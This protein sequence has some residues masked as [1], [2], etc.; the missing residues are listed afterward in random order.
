MKKKTIPFNV[1]DD[2]WDDGH[3]PPGDVQQTFGYIEEYE[4]IN[5]KDKEPI[6]QFIYDYI[7]KHIDMTEVKMEILGTQIEFINLTHV[8]REYMMERLGKSK[9]QYNGVSIDFYSES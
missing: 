8:K 5:D 1:W 2:Y 7:K 6:I 3:V 4:D 9:L